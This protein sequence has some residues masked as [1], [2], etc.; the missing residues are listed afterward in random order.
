MTDW[1][2][3][4]RA[5]LPELGASPLPPQIELPIFPRVV[6]EFLRRADDPNSDLKSVSR[7][8]ETDSNLTCELLRHVNSASLGRRFKAASVQQAISTLGLRRSKLFLMTAAVQSS[9]RGIRSE[10]LDLNDFWAANLE[11]GVFAREIALRVGGDPDVAYT[12]AMLQDFLLPVMSDRHI[13]LYRQYM[14]ERNLRSPDLVQFERARFSCDHAALAAACLLKWE[15]PDEL[16]CAVLLHHMSEE[17][18]HEA[19]LEETSIYGV[20]AS[21]LLPD[22]LGQQ[23]N[24]L[25]R[26]LQRDQSC[27]KFDLFEVAE[28]VDRQMSELAGMYGNRAPLLDRLEQH[29]AAHLSQMHQDAMSLG[30]RVGQYTLEEKLGEGAMGV[31]YRAR[32]DMLRRPTAVKLLHAKSMTADS[33]RLFEQ[34][35]QLTS[36]LEHPNTIS[37][38]DYGLTP[39]GL[40][41]YAMEYLEGMDLRQLVQLYGPMPGGRVT[42]ILAQVASALSEAHGRGLVH[43]DIKPENIFIGRRAGRGDAVKVLD[44][45]LVRHLNSQG[46]KV[47]ENGL[48]G[49]PAYL[50][51]EAIENPQ[52]VDQRADLYSLAAVGYFLLT[53]KT[54]FTGNSIIDL[55]LQQVTAAPPKPSARL[56]AP[57]DAGLEAIIM[58]CL[59]KAPADRPADAQRLQLLLGAL[60]VLTTWSDA[61]ADAWWSHHEKLREQGELAVAAAA[62]N[63]Y[64]ATLVGA[65][66]NGQ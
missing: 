15:F 7:V 48:T 31:V 16:V 58:Q 47:H 35:V 61:D 1:T 9:L 10:L 37:I 52:S 46:P 56:G 21:A 34:E 14:K 27:R 54:V 65:S 41:Y 24:G 51:P 33:A 60:P 39:E 22:P 6:G 32:H 25:G 64:D 55:C 17:A 23:N 42:R 20:T 4:R 49:T 45:G 2:A 44:F 57:V 63:E 12:G 19:G 62:P 13:E 50:A 26:L 36:E 66:L 59:R 30:R 18:L 53:G 29:V 40:F 8:I 38:Y 28:V 5:Y 43:R 11:R 3:I